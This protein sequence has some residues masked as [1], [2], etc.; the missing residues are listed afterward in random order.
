MESAALYTTTARKRIIDIW[1]WIVDRHRKNRDK[2]HQQL[3]DERRIVTTVMDDPLNMPGCISYQINSV[4]DKYVLGTPD[5][6]LVEVERKHTTDAK[7]NMVTSYLVTNKTFTAC[8]PVRN[9]NPLSFLELQ[10]RYTMEFRGSEQSGNFT[11]KHKTLSEIVSELKNGNALSEYGLDVAL[12]A[13]I[14]GFEKAG[15]LE[16][17]DDMNYT[18]SKCFGC[19]L[20]YIMKMQKEKQKKM[21]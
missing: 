9:K 14:K 4:P 19:N 16:V 18:A 1:R 6:K 10:Q 15:L 8:K 21:A 13:Q 7:S 17:N 5:N 20:E 3:E 2:Q 12:T 11:I